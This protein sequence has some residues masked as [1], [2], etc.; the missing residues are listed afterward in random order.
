MSRI[1]F[2]HFQDELYRWHRELAMTES[3]RTFGRRNLAA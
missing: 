2:V 1:L 3:R